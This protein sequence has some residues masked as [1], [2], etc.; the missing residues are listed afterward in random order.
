[1]TSICTVLKYSHQNHLKTSYWFCL[2]I[3][4]VFLTW[5]F[6]LQSMDATNLDV[7]HFQSKKKRVRTDFEIQYKYMYWYPVCQK[8]HLCV[9]IHVKVFWFNNNLYDL[10]LVSSVW[11]VCNLAQSLGIWTGISLYKPS[12]TCCGLSSCHFLSYCLLASFTPV[13]RILLGWDTAVHHCVCVV[14]CVMC[15]CLWAKV[16]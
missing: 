12:S 1:M 14:F 13:N 11:C 8:I 15:K 6:F 16:H 4:D 10:K 3:K 7:S 2:T 9:A 5:G